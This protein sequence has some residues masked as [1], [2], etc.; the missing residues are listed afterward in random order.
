[1]FWNLLY[2]LFELNSSVLPCYIDDIKQNILTMKGTI[3]LMKQYTKQYIAGIWR[4]GTSEHTLTNCNPLTG[5]VLYSYR[6][7]SQ[8][9]VDE[10]YAAAAQAQEVWMSTPPAHKKEMMQKL[11]QD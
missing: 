10:A 11:G 7:A 6:A 2:I 9:D 5:E 8:Q 1:Q 3:S 4:E